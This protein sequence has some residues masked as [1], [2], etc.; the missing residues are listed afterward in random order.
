MLY[1][2][3]NSTETKRPEILS[4][5]IEEFPI[6]NNQ[7]EPSPWLTEMEVKHVL[8]IIRDIVEDNFHSKVGYRTLYRVYP[9]GRIVVSKDMVRRNDEINVVVKRS[10]TEI[11][12]G[13]NENERI[14]PF[15]VKTKP[16][17][18]STNLFDQE[19]NE[20]MPEQ[21]MDGEMPAPQQMVER[22]IHVDYGIPDRE[23]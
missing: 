20:P 9:N 13:R 10:I 4:P 3:L 21:P 23:H 5:G 22:D 2:K 6:Y 11:R 19:V 15:G 7:F 14:N 18:F 8:S 17:L 12:S 1:V 16:E